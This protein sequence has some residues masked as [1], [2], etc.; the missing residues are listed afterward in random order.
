M[1]F[2]ILDMGYEQMGGLYCNE[3]VDIEIDHYANHLPPTL[4]HFP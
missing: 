4:N 1:K 2:K 3:H